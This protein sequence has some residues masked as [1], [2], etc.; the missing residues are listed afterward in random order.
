LLEV[1]KN[2]LVLR[3]NRN[4]A[5]ECEQLHM[6]RPS[7]HLS[8]PPYHAGDNLGTKKLKLKT[9]VVEEEVQQETVVSNELGFP[10]RSQVK[11]WIVVAVL[12]FNTSSSLSF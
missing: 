12:A 8:G 10:H 7:Y 11:N 1:E 5:A 2:E 9:S 3:K 4:M 6:K